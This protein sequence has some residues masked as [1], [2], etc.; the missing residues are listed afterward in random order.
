MRL[1]IIRIDNVVIIDGE[2]ARV[3]LSAMLANYHAVQWHGDHGEIE[4]VRG[5]NIP[6]KDLDT[7]RRFI[8]QAQTVIAD[9]KSKLKTEEGQD[10]EP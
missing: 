8:K 7:F 9:R 1:T 2:V 5:D 4:T 10:D 3:D 6:L